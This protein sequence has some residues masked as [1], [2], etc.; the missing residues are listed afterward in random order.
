MA[1]GLRAA[2]AAPGLAWGLYP[3]RS[4]GSDSRTPLIERLRQRLGG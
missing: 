2:V 1:A 4:N 3:Q